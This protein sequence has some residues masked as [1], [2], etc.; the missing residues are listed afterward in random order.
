[1]MASL[2]SSVRYPW[3]TLVLS[4]LASGVGH[5]YCGQFA[6]GVT[7]YA[8]R[9]LLP[10]LCLVAAF[11]EPSTGVFVGLI[12]VPAVVTC[13]IFL[14]SAYDAW[15]VAKRSLNAQSGYAWKPFNKVTVYVAL[16]AAQLVFLVALTWGGRKYVY[17]AFLIPVS[18]MSPSFLPGDRIL[19][20]KQTAESFPQRGDVVV[21]R[22]PAMEPD[23]I[24]IKRVV[25]VAGDQIV[26]RGNRIEVNGTVLERELATPSGS[27]SDGD[28]YYESQNDRRYRVIISGDS[29]VA[30][31]QDE[32]NT[33]E[34]RYDVPEDSLFVL[35]DNRGRSRDSRSFGPIPVNDVVGRVDYI[36]YPAASWSRFGVFRD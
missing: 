27:T 12:L 8:A 10:L 17:E 28:V 36:Y 34:T 3:L 35:G 19:V 26:I 5:L 20:N 6:K 2:Q 33:S 29:P 11:L 4:F 21:F 13:L 22:S 31:E 16:I 18:T 9:F 30:T 1:M 14:Y 24:W 23:R 7:L 32:A 15:S 25:G